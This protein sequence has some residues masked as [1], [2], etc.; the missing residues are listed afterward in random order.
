MTFTTEDGRRTQLRLMNRLRPHYIRIAIALKFPQHT[1]ATL[2]HYD[3]PVYYLLSE[4]LRGANQEVDPRPVTWGTLITA[5]RDAN[6]PEEVKML[7]KYLIE[8]SSHQA[9]TQ[10]INH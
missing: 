8:H 5:L 3:D 2:E 9:E 7:E 1:V 6:F 4:W 10:G